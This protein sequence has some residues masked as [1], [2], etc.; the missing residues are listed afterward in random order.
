MDPRGWEQLRPWLALPMRM[1]VD[2]SSAL[3]DGPT[4]GRLSSSDAARG[5]LRRVAAKAAGAS[6]RT[7]SEV[8]VGTGHLRGRLIELVFED[9]QRMRYSLTAT[10]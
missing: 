9:E 2:N 1:P 7:S 4:Y 10:V 8:A 3:I 5:R 6:R